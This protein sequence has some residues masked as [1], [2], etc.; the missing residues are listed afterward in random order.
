MKARA[1][2]LLLLLLA[3]QLLKCSS[4]GVHNSGAQSEER[5]PIIEVSTPDGA[6]TGKA[7]AAAGRFATMA[8]QDNSVCFVLVHGA[9]REFQNANH[10]EPL[11]EMFTNFGDVMAL[12]MPGHGRTSIQ[13]ARPDIAPSLVKGA[14]NQWC[15]QNKWARACK[16]PPRV[17]L[18]GRSWGGGVVLAAAKEIG[19]QRLA[20]L[21]LIAPSLGAGQL[22]SLPA[23]LLEAVPVLIFWARDDSIVPFSNAAAVAST[24]SLARLRAVEPVLE[25]GMAAWKAHVPELERPAQFTAALAD[26]MGAVAKRMASSRTVSGSRAANEL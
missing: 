1:A 6:A 21:V 13:N 2:N 16:D 20:G 12:D 22:A 26:F 10:W 17:V 19:V 7:L 14:A 4:G 24:F 5:Y 11:M 3:L 25:P 9:S 15:Q 23:D 8:A 18:V